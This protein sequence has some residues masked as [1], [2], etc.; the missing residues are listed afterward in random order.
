M[1]SPGAGPNLSPRN[2]LWYG[3]W[4]AIG[5]VLL[6]RL[7]FIATYPLNDF[8][9][10][11]ANYGRMLLQGK[12][13]LVH[14]GGYPFLIGLPFR[15]PGVQWLLSGALPYLILCLQHTID[16][17]V[18]LFLYRVVSDL[19]GRAAGTVAV[20][21]LGLNVRALA[22]TSTTCPEWLQADLFLLA[23]GTAYYAF[24]QRVFR[25]KLWLYSLAAFAFSWC[26]LVKFN[27]AVVAFFLAS[28]SPPFS[29]WRR[30]CGV[31]VRSP[32]WRR[33]CHCGCTITHDRDVCA[34]LRGGSC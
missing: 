33:L 8:G 12:S 24:V 23:L 27:V 22:A 19:Y 1:T 11:S 20:L 25:R 9:E 7:L 15:I 21:L 13:S 16:V 10:D 31:C 3:P 6:I 17:L 26:V 14:A 30:S 32:V 4:G 2:V 29:R 34:Y 5:F 18:L 28:P